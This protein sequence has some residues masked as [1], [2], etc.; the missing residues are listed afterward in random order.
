MVKYQQYKYL[1]TTLKKQKGP[2]KDGKYS[3]LS[4]VLST[5]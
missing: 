1:I 4:K 2:I 5:I 3:L